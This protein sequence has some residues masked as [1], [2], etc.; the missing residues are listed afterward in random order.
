MSNLG[1]KQTLRYVATV[2][3]TP[4]SGYQKPSLHY[5]CRSSSGSL[6]LF[7][8]IRRAST[9]LLAS[10]HVFNAQRPGAQTPDRHYFTVHVSSTARRDADAH[11][12]HLTMV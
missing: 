6:A 1:Q 2:R 10:R 9:K 5:V 7:P 4:K 8:A 3:F 11:S 12:L